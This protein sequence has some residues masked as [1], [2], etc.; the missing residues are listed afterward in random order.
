PTGSRARGRRRL[1][2][3]G[4]HRA[5]T[6]AFVLLQ[7]TNAT[8][9]SILAVYAPQTMGLDVVWAGIALGAAAGL[10]VP[11]LMIVARLTTRFSSLVLILTSCVAGI[12]YYLGV[13]VATGPVLLI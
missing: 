7:A 12:A 6:A 8:G 9:M 3:H 10:E 11:A 4:G 1:P 5:V 2:R 13:A